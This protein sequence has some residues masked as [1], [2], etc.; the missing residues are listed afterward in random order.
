[1]ECR[2]T[3]EIVPNPHED[4][5]DDWVEVLIR[6]VKSLELEVKE[7]RGYSPSPPPPGPP[8]ATMMGE[9]SRLTKE[10]QTLKSYLSSI[11]HQANYAL[12]ENNDD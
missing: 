3:D 4:G 9:I 6:R 12:G 5:W 8:I 1:M 2:I 7:L 11:A 10:N